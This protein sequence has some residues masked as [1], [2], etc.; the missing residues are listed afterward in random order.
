MYPES[1]TIPNKQVAIPHKQLS[2]SKCLH[3]LLAL[4][5]TF[6]GILFKRDS[7]Q[8]ENYTGK[9]RIGAIHNLITSL[10]QHD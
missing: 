3:I 7:F 5:A 1:E 10:L 6:L 8:H 4:L 9:C 2:I